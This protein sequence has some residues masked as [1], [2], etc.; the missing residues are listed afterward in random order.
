MLRSFAAADA[1]TDL[2]DFHYADLAQSLGG[3]GERVETCSELAEALKR[4]VEEEGCF[5]L[6][7]AMLPRGSTSDA[8]Q[9]FTQA[10]RRISALANE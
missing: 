10:I 6:I 2:A 4:A 8:L 1:Y 3:K 9:R 7:E 5:Y